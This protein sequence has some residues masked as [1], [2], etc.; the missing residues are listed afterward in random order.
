MH[1]VIGTDQR[2][3]R[4]GHG[5]RDREKGVLTIAGDGRDRDRIGV[6]QAWWQT[7]DKRIQMADELQA[8]AVEIHIDR[9]VAISDDRT[10]LVVGQQENGALHGADLELA[11]AG[12]LNGRRRLLRDNV[13]GQN[14]TVRAIAAS[15]VEHAAQ[16][17]H[18]LD[19]DDAG[20]R[21]DNV[22]ESAGAA[23]V[24]ANRSGAL[25]RSQHPILTDIS[26]R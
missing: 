8:V 24:N 16:D 7:E 4:S 6:R 14:I 3:R 26:A 23:Q 17:R 1:D 9:Q 13:V 19:R 15:D 18:R 12:Q 20:S 2:L 5:Q 21:K 10:G 22:G 11:D 25:R